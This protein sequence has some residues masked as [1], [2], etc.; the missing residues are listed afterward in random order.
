MALQKESQQICRTNLTMTMTMMTTRR[1]KMM[2]S[3]RRIVAST[4]S[5]I[6]IQTMTYILRIMEHLLFDVDTSEYVP[7]GR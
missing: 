5:A 3:K 4:L 1:M 2:Q 7:S 6:A